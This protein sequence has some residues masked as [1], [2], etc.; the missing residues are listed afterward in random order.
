MSVCDYHV[1]V[2]VSVSLPCAL[3]VPTEPDGVPTSLALDACKKTDQWHFDM[4]E[5]ST[6][7]GVRETQQNWIGPDQTQSTASGELI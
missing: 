1:N 6:A 2:G 4:K 5:N 7:Q 3:A